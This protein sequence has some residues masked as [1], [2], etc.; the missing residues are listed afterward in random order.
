MLEK[1]TVVLGDG[2]DADVFGFEID[3]LEVAVQIFTVRGGRIRGQ[4]GWVADRAD[5]TDVPELVQ[6][7]L[8]TLYG[9]SAS[10]G[11]APPGARARAAGGRRRRHRAALG[12]ARRPGHDPRPAPRRQEAR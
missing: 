12:A 5:D 2:T 11:R 9:E 10:R 8:V 3:P 7:A 4:R 6:R 1:Q